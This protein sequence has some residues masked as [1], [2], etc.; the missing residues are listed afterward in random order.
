MNRRA[1]RHWVEIACHTRTKTHKKNQEEKPSL[2][3]RKSGVR[4]ESSVNEFPD[5]S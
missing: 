1:D 5:G 2:E 3:T 4:A